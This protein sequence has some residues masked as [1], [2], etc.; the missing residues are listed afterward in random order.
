MDT[1]TVEY[2]SYLYQ[3]TGLYEYAVKL[4]LLDAKARLL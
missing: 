3:K 2:L 1:N 4:K